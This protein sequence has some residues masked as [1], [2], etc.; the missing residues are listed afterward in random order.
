MHTDS[1][2]ISY[3]YFIFF[4][5]RKVSLKRVFKKWHVRIWTGF[6]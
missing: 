2:V 3:A 5:I 1:N 6:A 4:K